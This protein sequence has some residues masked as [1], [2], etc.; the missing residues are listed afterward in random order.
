MGSKVGENGFLHKAEIYEFLNFDQATF[1][2]NASKENEIDYEVIVSGN[3][4][5]CQTNES[6]KNAAGL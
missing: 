2:A 1:F 4:I 5:F 3:S 6:A